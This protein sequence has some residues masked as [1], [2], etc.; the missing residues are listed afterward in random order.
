[1]RFTSGR[2][3]DAVP[4]GTARSARDPGA[5]RP[6]RRILPL[7]IRASLVVIVLIPI[8]VAV[9][10][11]SSVVAHQ[12]AQRD[13]AVQVR[14][15]SLALDALLRA[16]IAVYAEYVP[17][18]AIVAARVN[19]LTETQL[20]ALV[21][22][23]FKENLG[24]ARTAVDQQPGFGPHGVFAADH[25]ALVS[26]RH[27][28]DKGTASPAQVETFFS[29][30][31]TKVD[32]DWMGTFNAI[33]NPRTSGAVSTSARLT[34]LDASF[35][36]FT[37]GLGEE[38]LQN[39]GS[40]ET[41]LVDVATPAAIQSLIVS[42]H[43]FRSAT[44]DFP[45]LLGPKSAAAWSALNRNPLTTEFQ[46][47]VQLG[48][49]TGLNHD[50]PP[51]PSSAP[52]V[53]NIAR[54]EVEWANALTRLVLASSVDL[55]LAT[56][57]QTN[58]AT[59]ALDVSLLLITLIIL[60]SIGGVLTLSRAVRRPIANL[61]AAFESVRQGELEVPHLDESGPRELAL[62]ASAFNE[63]TSTLRGVQAQAIALSSGNLD[64]P[65][66]QTPLPGRM[67]EALQS[68]LS[69]LHIS[70]QASEIQRE[71]LFE[72]ATRDA[73]TGLLNRGA[74]LE[75]LNIDLAGRAAAKATWF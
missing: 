38:S 17:S 65:A 49:T 5:P 54:S 37:S 62:A 73:L 16:R 26:L 11:T 43:M 27:A 58:S 33:Q 52:A 72:R 32:A 63:M 35:A 60:L 2:P 55:R 36:A 25:R 1:M 40:L 14:Q 68:A 12:V 48:I 47:Y 61:G 64:D 42:Q 34:A 7:S 29:S 70:M 3:T 39:N 15:S 23:N 18:A 53:G 50:G 31:G 20:D 46:G 44:H 13:Q 74:A 66:L 56:A 6:K 9:G 51:F 22:I 45:R 75:S 19:D 24:K 71:E 67:G 21:G 69:N 59:S 57:D 30:L 28:V 4:D 8:T 10:L 41:V